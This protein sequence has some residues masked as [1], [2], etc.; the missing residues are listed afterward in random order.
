MSG[1]FPFDIGKPGI[2]QAYQLNQFRQKQ[3]GRLAKMEVREKKL[4]ARIQKLKNNAVYQEFEIR[5]TLGYIG[6]DE[7]IFHFRSSSSN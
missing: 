5:K 1:I 2:L 4:L 6:A 7:V 3:Q